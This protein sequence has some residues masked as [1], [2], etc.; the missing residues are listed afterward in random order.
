M[1][2]ETL[3]PSGL[4]GA[5]CPGTVSSGESGDGTASGGGGGEGNDEKI[6]KK[7]A[8]SGALTAGARGLPIEID[9]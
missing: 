9:K 2:S 7:A 1:T 8:A 5:S 4:G 6:D 3:I